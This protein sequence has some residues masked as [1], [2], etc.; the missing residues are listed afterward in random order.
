[1]SPEEFYARSERLRKE[2][3]A[4][5]EAAEKIECDAHIASLLAKQKSEFEEAAAKVFVA[6]DP[7]ARGHW[8]HEEV[9]A[10]RTGKEVDSDG[11]LTARA[12]NETL[13]RQTQRLAAALER[14]GIS[15]HREG[16][17]TSLVGLVTGQSVELTSYRSI[18]FLPLVAQRERREFVNQYIYMAETDHKVGSFARYF[19]FTNDQ[20]IP[21]GGDLRGAMDE[22]FRE[23]VAL[24]GMLKKDFGVEILLR[25]TEMPIAERECAVR[26]EYGLTVAEM[27]R[28]VHLHSNLSVLPTRF[29]GGDGWAKVLRSIHEMFPGRQIQDCGKV[30]DARELIK[31]SVKPTDLENADD[32]EIAWL[33]R[34]TSRAHIVQPFNRFRVLRASL[35]QQRLKVIANPEKAEEGVVQTVIPVLKEERK[36]ECRPQACDVDE[37]GV[38]DRD[39]TVDGDEPEKKVKA[40]LLGTTTPQPLFS[41]FLE[42]CVLIQNYGE[43]MEAGGHTRLKLLMTA[44]RRV[45]DES[46]APAPEAALRL[47]AGLSEGIEGRIVSLRREASKRA[48]KKAAARSGGNRIGLTHTGYRFSD[49]PDDEHD[50]GP[51]RDLRRTG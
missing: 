21:V 27:L 4:A 5:R 48:K 38:V 43:E 51:P 34:E 16:A 2:K 15:A 40:Y 25:A 41:P 47:A 8:R 46:G 42:P 30:E 45:W 3:V 28:A 11:W 6:R 49:P 12:R 24:G 13:R 31:Y 36:K 18:R 14:Q 22:H 19:V 32:E 17:T 29:L 35:K 26:D 50:S 23:V 1:V 39:D 37:D 9:I 7:A 33:Y 44:A 10:H 20:P